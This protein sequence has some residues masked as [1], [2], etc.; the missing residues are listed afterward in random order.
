MCL[1]ILITIK[2]MF[3]PRGSA[4]NTGVIL[5]VHQASER[6]RYFV[7]TSLIGWVEA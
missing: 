2:Y 4:Y 3:V 5:G 7:T 1:C 6:R